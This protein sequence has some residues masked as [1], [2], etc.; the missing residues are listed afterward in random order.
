M[1][2]INGINKMESSSEVGL[3]QAAVPWRFGQ[4]LHLLSELCVLRGYFVPVFHQ[5]MSFSVS[6]LSFSSFDYPSVD[7][8][9]MAS[10][11]GLRLIVFVGNWVQGDWKVFGQN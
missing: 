8:G 4:A 2:R 10:L 11:P 6:R 3:R 7:S 1:D 5:F 9:R